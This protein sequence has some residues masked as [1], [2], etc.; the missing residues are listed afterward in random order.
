VSSDLNL[1][2]LDE[3]DPL[4]IDGAPFGWDA[5]TDL[6]SWWRAS[7]PWLLYLIPAI[8]VFW[9][10]IYHPSAVHLTHNMGDQ[11]FFEWVLSST[12]DAVKGFHNPLFAGSMNAPNGVNLM[13]NNGILLLGVPLTPLTLLFGAPLTLAVIL[14]GN[15]VGTA[16]AWRW[17]FSRRLPSAGEPEAAIPAQ[18]RGRRGRRAAPTQAGRTGIS[19]VVAWV[20]GLVCGFGPGLI[21]HSIGHPNLSAQW[22]APLIVD[23]VLRLCER[24]DWRRDGVILGLLIAGQVFLSEEIALITAVA[25]VLFLVLFAVQKPAAARAAL[26]GL[27][28]GAGIAAVVAG[29]IVAYPLWFQF[30][31]PQSYT[32]IPDSPL[33][34]A[35]NIKSYL[36]FPAQSLAGGGSVPSGLGVTATEQGALLG[37]PLLALFVVAAIF[38][39]RNAAARAATLTALVAIA[40]SFGPQ[41]KYGRSAAGIKGLWYYVESLPVVKDALPERVA[42]AVVP[43]IVFVVFGAVQRLVG[44]TSPRP[45]RIGAWVA[46]AAALVP[47]IPT[48]IGTT[49][50][51]HLPAFIADGLWSQCVDR[52]RTMLTVPIASDANRETMRWVGYSGAA[53]SVPGTNAFVPGKTGVAQYGPNPTKTASLLD[54]IDKTGTIPPITSAV[55]AQAAKDLTYWGVQCV[56]V[57]P[58]SP[59]ASQDKKALNSIL[60]QGQLIGGVWTWRISG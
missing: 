16:A 59:H 40:L 39:I 10:T 18:G 24:R 13:A 17:F 3:Q 9:S 15:L 26:P 56:A 52:G 33:T 23:R 43:L 47:L 29:A 48:P 22:L 1:D 6:R 38:R 37:W 45:A 20:A 57:L 34:H 35:A 5:K 4:A 55:R 32:A 51:A 54:K 31:G 19:P 41:P 49:D 44:R 50:R 12:A 25:L 28:G 21:S 2:N 7:W 30:K 46:A 8:T 27:G 53:F 58:S 14:V 42:L 36:A 60:G 11:Y